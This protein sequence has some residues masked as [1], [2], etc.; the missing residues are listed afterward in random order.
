MPSNSRPW[1]H[2]NR[3]FAT[4][5]LNSSNRFAWDSGPGSPWWES[6]P[7]KSRGAVAVEVGLKPV[8]DTG[9]SFC[10]CPR[11]GSPCFS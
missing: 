1:K 3:L 10:R 8:P 6:P 2:S 11:M 5:G 9:I 7:D 4:P